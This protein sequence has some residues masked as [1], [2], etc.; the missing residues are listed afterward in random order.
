MKKKRFDW[1][2]VFIVIGVLAF[3]ALVTAGVVWARTDVEDCL[4]GLKFKQHASG[5]CIA[6]TYCNDDLV[7]V[8]VDGR[9]CQ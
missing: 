4:D 9:F 2:S 5:L 7:T 6:H 3:V 8:A 1:D